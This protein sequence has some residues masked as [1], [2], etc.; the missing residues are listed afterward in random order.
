MNVTDHPAPRGA[1]I[2]LLEDDALI[3]ID[4]ED[5]LRAI[6]AERVFVAHTLEAA[7][8]IVA[9]EAIDAAVL[10]VL[11][12][13]GRSDALARLLSGRRIPVVFASGFGDMS[14]PDDLRHIPKVEKPYSGEALRLAFAAAG[15]AGP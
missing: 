13:R 7:A 6:G 3:S 5:M 10:D 12:G 9:R 11:I 8:E 2:L 1:S 14:M 4:A 15:L